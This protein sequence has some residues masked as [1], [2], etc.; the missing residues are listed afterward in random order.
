MKFLHLIQLL[1]IGT[2]YNLCKDNRA[3]H[4]FLSIMEGE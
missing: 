3:S 2:Q 4:M 1:L